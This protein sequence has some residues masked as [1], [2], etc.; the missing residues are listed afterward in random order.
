MI[1]EIVRLITDAA[2]GIDKDLERILKLIY[3]YANE[4]RAEGYDQAK[5][6]YEV[7]TTRR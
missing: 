2:P 4:A 6:H 1:E 3:K 5:I 7:Y